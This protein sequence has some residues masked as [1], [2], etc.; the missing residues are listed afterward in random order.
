MLCLWE[1]VLRP[2]HAVSKLLQ[3]RDM[4]L[5]NARDRLAESFSSIQYIRNDYVSIV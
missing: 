4:D 3:Q 5:H 2:M 1:R